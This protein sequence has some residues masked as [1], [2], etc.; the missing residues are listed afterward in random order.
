MTSASREIDSG[1]AL[2]ASAISVFRSIKY[3]SSRAGPY[4]DTVFWRPEHVHVPGRPL[5]PRPAAQVLLMRSS[6]E[7]LA[8]L[9]SAEIGFSF[10][11]TEWHS[12]VRSQTY[13]W[14]TRL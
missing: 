10:Y 2:R 3:W 11:T 6:R 8:P 4:S 12:H 7:C 9:V 5:R 14:T 13:C 1:A